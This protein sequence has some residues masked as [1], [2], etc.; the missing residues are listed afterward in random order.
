MLL[1]I[2]IWPACGQRLTVIAGDGAR[3]N[4]S[5]ITHISITKVGQVTDIATLTH[6]RALQLAEVAYVGATIN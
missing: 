5:T 6:M 4:V 1:E 2:C 3:P